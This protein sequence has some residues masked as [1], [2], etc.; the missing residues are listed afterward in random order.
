MKIFGNDFDRQE[1][2]KRTGDIT[3]L[4]GIRFFEFSLEL[5]FIS[6]YSPY[7]LIKYAYAKVP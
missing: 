3:Q 5:S 7:L 1:I 2:S 4:G 6:S